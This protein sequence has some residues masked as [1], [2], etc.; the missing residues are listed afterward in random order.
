MSSQMTGF[1][2]FLFLN[3]ILLCLYIMFLNLFASDEHL[4]CFHVL[5]IVINVIINM[6]VQMLVQHTDLIF[7]VYVTSKGIAESYSSTFNF[8]VPPYC[9]P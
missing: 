8:R 1:Y 2:P 4:G 5:T 3:N 6:G 9:F 7:S